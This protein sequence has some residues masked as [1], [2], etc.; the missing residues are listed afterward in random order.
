MMSE[1]DSQ[2]PMWSYQVN[3]DKRVRDDHPRGINRVVNTPKPIESFA[4]RPIRM[5]PWSAAA[6]ATIT[7]FVYTQPYVLTEASHNQR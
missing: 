2:K 6:I 4:V 3:L 5:Q 7:L 1:S